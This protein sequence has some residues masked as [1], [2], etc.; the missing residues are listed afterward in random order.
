MPRARFSTFDHMTHTAYAWLADIASAF[1]TDD[2]RFAYR[3][4]RAW[5]HT[6]R[7]R[8]T[9]DGAVKFGAQLPE[10]LR[11]V[12]YDG[13]NLSA[14]PVK[15][16][17]DEYMQRFADEARISATEVPTAAARISATMWQRFSP[18]QLDEALAE[19]PE[20]LR[21]LLAGA[22]LPP[23]DTEPS[24]APADDRLARLET[25]VGEL[26]EALQVLVHG[27]EDRPDLTEPAE[28]RTARAARRAHELL[29]AAQR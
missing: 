25:Q 15:F 22:N 13:W 5:L 18:G 3:V 2:R 1:G 9:P 27:M 4:L 11:G 26:A 20:P 12:Y 14:A 8:L 24:G 28:Q 21:D 6:L 17:P 10:L 23:A 7:D 19:L 16:G 29:L